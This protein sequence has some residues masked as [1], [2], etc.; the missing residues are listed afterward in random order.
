MMSCPATSSLYSLS[1]L[2]LRLFL[3]VWLSNESH[4]VVLAAVGFGCLPAVSPQQCQYKFHL[5]RL[6]NA[7]G[8]DLKKIVVQYPWIFCMLSCHLGGSQLSS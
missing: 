4:M 6:V 5:Q 7:R 3:S 2:A 8:S 1:F